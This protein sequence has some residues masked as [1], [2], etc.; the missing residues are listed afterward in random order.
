MQ[1]ELNYTVHIRLDK[2]IRVK[3]GQ[4]YSHRC[5]TFLQVIVT[6]NSLKAA[7]E[8]DQVIFLSNRQHAHGLSH[9]QFIDCMTKTMTL[10][11]TVLR[12]I[13]T[14]AKRYP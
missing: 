10:L 14:D 8:T 12:Y 13:D 1:I 7:G 4:L 11:L 6:V 2:M 5:A 9:R 3:T